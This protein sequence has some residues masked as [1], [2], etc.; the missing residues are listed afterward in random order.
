MNTPKITTLLGI[1]AA[2]VGTISATTPAFGVTLATLNGT[3]ADADAIA[4]VTF[5][6]PSTPVNFK[7]TSYSTGNFSP[8]LTLFDASDNYSN[9]YIDIEDLDLDL[10]LAPGTYRA[11]ISTFGRFFDFATNSNFSAGFSGSGDFGLNASG[12]AP[13]GANYDLTIST[14]ATAVPEPSSI[15]GTALTGVGVVLFRRKL[16]TRSR[17][18]K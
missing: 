8:L 10:T 7:T 3:L 16:S 15:I 9:E 14:V 6:A 5:I 12:T 13:R 11:V 18:L 4:S 17:K 2:T 1:V